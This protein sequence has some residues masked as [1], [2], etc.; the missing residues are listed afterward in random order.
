ML[1]CQLHG[2]LLSKMNEKTF[3]SYAS[4]SISLENKKMT[5]KQ[6]HQERQRETA[7]LKL[8]LGLLIYRQ[9]KREPRTERERVTADIHIYMRRKKNIRQLMETGCLTL[10]TQ[11]FFIILLTPKYALAL[12]TNAGLVE[13]QER[14]KFAYKSSRGHSR[15]NESFLLTHRRLCPN[16][17]KRFSLTSLLSRDDFKTRKKNINGTIIMQMKQ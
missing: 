8:W 7:L 4:H 9:K 3:N 12:I 16:T 14:R 10:R 17:K 13:K 6:Q 1:M 11:N 5:S 2:S 15:E